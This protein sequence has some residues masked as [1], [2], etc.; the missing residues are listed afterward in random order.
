[1]VTVMD[2]EMNTD[3]N[4]DKA[5]DTDMDTDMNIDTYTGHEY[6]NRNFVKVWCVLSR[7]P[8][9]EHSLNTKL[10]RNCNTSQFRMFLR[11]IKTLNKIPISWK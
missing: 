9:F 10:S 3:K 5:T 8:I 2:T 11:K 4:M 1:M 6:G 7:R